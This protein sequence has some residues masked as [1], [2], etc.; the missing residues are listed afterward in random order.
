M[1]P[2]V[3]DHGGTPGGVVTLIPILLVLAAVIVF[4]LVV[5]LRYRNGPGGD[6]GGGGGRDGG[7]DNRRPSPSDPR[8]DGEPGWWPEFERQFA[9]YVRDRQ[10]ASRT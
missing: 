1:T 8:P 5:S 2:Q 10:P 7:I 6:D 9:A 3:A 4:L